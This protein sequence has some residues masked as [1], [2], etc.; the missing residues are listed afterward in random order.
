MSLPASLTRYFGNLG[1]ILGQ[2]FVLDSFQLGFISSNRGCQSLTQ[3]KSN[4]KQKVTGSQIF[5]N[6][7]QDKE[8]TGKDK[9][10]AVKDA[11]AVKSY[12]FK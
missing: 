4:S 7:D 5:D 11:M 3:I 12:A 1:P 9:E 8:L 2:L 6:L 10:L